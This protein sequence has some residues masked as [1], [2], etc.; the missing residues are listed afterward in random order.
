MI[1]SALLL[2]S[3]KPIAELDI[4]RAL[5]SYDAVHIPSPQDRD[6]ITPNAWNYVAFNMPMGGNMGAVRPLGKSNNYDALYENVMK[7]CQPALEQG[8]I[9]EMSMP[10]YTSELTFG[11][12]LLPQGI[13]DPV[14]I[15]DVYK[16]MAANPN[17]VNMIAKGIS[18]SE[19][20]IL[21]NKERIAPSG[22]DDL[23]IQAKNLDTGEEKDITPFKASYIDRNIS[24][25]AREAVSRLCLAR[26]GATVKNLMI[27][28]IKKVQPF[29][30]DEGMAAV[31]QMLNKNVNVS[32]DSVEKKDEN[33]TFAVRLSR[34]HKMVM[35]E[36]IDNDLLN[37]LTLEKLLK[38]RTKAWGKAR[39]ARSKLNV[40]L[41]LIARENE[42]VE[43][44]DSAC[45]KALRDYR[46]SFS[47]WG[48]ESR[49]FGVKTFCDLVPATASVPVVSNMIQKF[50]AV[51]S[52]DIWLWLGAAAM[53]M[54][55]VGEKIT[56]MMDLLKKRKD[57]MESPEYALFEPYSFVSKKST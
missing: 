56:G 23:N 15:Y 30:S 12:V 42:N 3:E 19:Q 54:P 31:I 55:S 13:P 48:H 50:V 34:L 45:E 37:R 43:D 49:K 26:L 14:F 4:K 11:G 20:Q 35:S 1:A 29:T 44:F 47:D 8:N 10:S 6:M 21:E 38:L 18:E 51:G 16:V 22:L 46:K 24:E 40:Q 27:C 36:F 57:I 52:I 2:P 25:E 28:H 5:L 7:K 39:E 9:I 53:V 17:F 32:I 41:Q 33:T